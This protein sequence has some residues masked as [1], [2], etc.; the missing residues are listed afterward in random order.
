MNRKLLI[1][2]L[3]NHGHT[4]E[5]SEDGSIGVEQARQAIYTG[6]LY[7]TILCDSQMPVMDGPTA[8]QEIRQ[9]VK[10]VVWKRR[11]FERLKRDWNGTK[12]FRNL[13]RVK[14]C[15]SH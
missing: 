11:R 14:Q 8:I 5:G 13:C 10:L 1:R 15:S 2:V 12:I 4:V 6:T 7:G 3:Q 9:F